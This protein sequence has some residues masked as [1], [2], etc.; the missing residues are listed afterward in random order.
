M[1]TSRIMANFTTKDQANKQATRGMREKSNVCA[2]G[3]MTI[4]MGNSEKIVGGGAI[5]R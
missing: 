5:I 4:N 3:E 2:G 1:A